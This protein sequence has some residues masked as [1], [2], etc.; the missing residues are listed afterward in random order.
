[1]A[2]P[3]RMTFLNPIKPESYSKAPQIT[4][5]M[6]DAMIQRYKL[7]LDFRIKGFEINQTRNYILT[8]ANKLVSSGENAMLSESDEITYY[9][10]NPS[11][12]QIHF[13]FF[14]NLFFRET[15]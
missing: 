12:D 9:Q 3:H 5:D 2:K 13:A 11:I 14:F 4:Q 10:K 1:M 7:D 6:Q 15:P 8:Q